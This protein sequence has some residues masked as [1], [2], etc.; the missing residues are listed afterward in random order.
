MLR[1]SSAWC[2]WG[3]LLALASFLVVGCGGQEG[4]KYQAPGGAPPRPT[5]PQA[6]PTATPDK[7]T[8][9]QYGHF[10]D[11][12]FQRADAQPL[13][14]FSAD[15]N[16][17]SYSNLRRM[18][19]EGQ[20][21]PQDAVRIAEMV[22]YF[23]Y[24]Y[25]KPVNGDPVA[26]QL[27]LGPCPWNASHHLLRIGMKAK[28]YSKAELPPRNLV[29]LVDVSGS[30]SGPT[31]LPLVKK[32][33]NLLI[34]QLSS[35]DQVSIV[36]YAG[37]TSVKLPPTSGA[38]KSRI[39]QVVNALKAYGSTN[40]ESG[41][42][43][44][45]DQARASYRSGAINR[46]ILCT[47]GD[48]NVGVTSLGELVRMIEVE[49]ES[50]VFLTV[51]GFGMGNLKDTTLEK[52]ANHGNGHYAYID[53]ESEA[54]KVFVEQGAS[55]VTVAKDVK[56]QVEFNPAR[57]QSY[58]L[59]GY[60]NRLLKNED[61]QN[62]AKDAGDIGSGHTVTALYEI[63]PHGVEASPQTPALK[64][65]STQ[66]IVPAK[67]G[68]WLTVKMRFKTPMGNKS[69]EVVQALGENGYS[70]NTPPDFAFAA[71]VA[72]FGMI[73]R[74]SPYKAQ[75]SLDRVLDRATA[76]LG[77]DVGNHRIEFTGLVRKIRRKQETLAAG[78]D[79]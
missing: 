24:A 18:I 25:P 9:E 55:L 1:S 34:D 2:G 60:E 4:M 71:A 6:A 56:L 36:T 44:A 48:F 38:D 54:Q 26:F 30:M 46:V 72:E 28:E 33:L 66:P 50:D 32:S 70:I 59:V 47:D 51:L 39:R 52:L 43:L 68:E 78:Q 10:E 73:L 12:P 21:I 27:N 57:V 62:D 11:N 77:P 8:Q 35:S 31:R 67:S 16:T 61:F 17:A 74:N 15:V 65:T 5:V 75:A 63:V 7:E 64:Y 23:P 76:N 14:T 79:R 45:Y 20:T 53:S 40:G 13:S 3:S 29:F 37:E 42:R 41:I 19:D 58:R 49:R 69:Q 22:N